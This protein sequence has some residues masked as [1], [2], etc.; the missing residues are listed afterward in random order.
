MDGTSE[1][2]ELGGDCTILSNFISK[3]ARKIRQNRQKTLS[4]NKLSTLSLCKCVCPIYVLILFFLVLYHLMHLYA[5]DDNSL[6]GVLPS[7]LFG[8]P[9]LSILS[10]GK[11]LMEGKQKCNQSC[12]ILQTKIASCL[13]ITGLNFLSGTLPSEI[14]NAKALKVLDLREFMQLL[15]II[16][17]ASINFFLFFLCFARKGGGQN[18][19]GRWKW[20]RL[21]GQ[22]PS[23]IG[24][25]SSLEVINFC[26]WYLV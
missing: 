26:K 3:F 13:Y 16:S 8:L 19:R 24:T 21:E 9:D 5:P 17:M 18:D 4:E 20:N 14:G 25:A 15:L 7:S 10:L 12:Y 23:E 6:A 11:L 2:P 22:I 1:E